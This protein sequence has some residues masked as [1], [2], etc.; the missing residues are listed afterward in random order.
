LL[1]IVR[2]TLMKIRL[3]EPRA[4]S[5]TVYD[6]ALLPRLGLPLIGAILT[7]H[8]HDVRIY[9]ETMAPVDW[10][11]L[12]DA[13]LIGFSTTTSTTPPAYE[14][15]DRLRSEGKTVVF[16]GAHVTFLSEEALA[17]SDFVVRGE[18]HTT[19]LELTT[20]L[21]KGEG[22]ESILGLSYHGE[23]GPVHNPDRPPCD[24]TAFAGLPAPDLSLIVG[25]D[26]MSTFPI[27]T[28]WGCPYNCE[29]CSVVKMFGRKVRARPL[30]IVLEELERVPAG[31][32]IFFYDDNLVVDKRRTKTL[33]RGM[34]AHGIEAPW[35]AQMR[36]EAIY[37]D[38]ETREWDAELLELMRD[39][40]CGWV[41]IGFE[42]V[43][44]AALEEYRKGQTVAHI[45][46]S[47]EAFHTY[48]I[49]VHGMFVLGCDADT[50]ATIRRTVSFAI[51]HGIDTVQFLTIT[52]LPGT[53]FYHRMQESGRILS[54][55]WS[56]YDGHHALILPANMTPYRL[57]VLSLRGMLRFYSLRRA[58]NMLCKSVFEELPFLVRLFFRERKVRIALPRI[59]ALSLRPEKWLAI[60]E[61]LQKAMDRAS[62]RRLR[63]AFIVPLFRG[64]ARKHIL[65]GMRQLRNQ[66]Y[67]AWLRSL[68]RRRSGP[69]TMQSR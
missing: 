8:G 28:Q 13:D 11:D 62:W 65:E 44:P 58:W 61:V 38:K 2:G 37:K 68:A 63:S 49:R 27:M 36:A 22:V 50:P 30:E 60:P 46:E 23:N 57:Q 53:D 19:I 69:E 51:R 21:E 32:D 56:F 40:H 42:S 7:Q 64:Y 34:I 47:I 29:F 20:A 31:K 33:L 41:Y 14:M 6:H 3:I 26:R 54:D 52:P 43:N 12:M 25:H 66:G 1:K 59:A 39:S 16:G 17:H 4:S 10:E 9:V 15:A 5:N 18:G 67:L 45:A 48:G 55:D 24:G 35:S